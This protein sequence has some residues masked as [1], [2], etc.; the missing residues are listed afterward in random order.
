VAS[1]LDE[2]DLSSEHDQVEWIQF[3]EFDEYEMAGQYQAIV[4]FGLV[5]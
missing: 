5:K 1:K 2:E 4:E 3:S